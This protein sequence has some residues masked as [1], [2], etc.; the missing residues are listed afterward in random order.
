MLYIKILLRFFKN[1]K[2]FNLSNLVLVCV[3]VAV[4]LPKI[5]EK[6]IVLYCKLVRLG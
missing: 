1:S 6:C 3:E 5:S 4:Q 2:N